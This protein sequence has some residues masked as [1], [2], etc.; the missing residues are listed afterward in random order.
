MDF[1]FDLSCYCVLLFFL[2]K[3]WSFVFRNYIKCVVD[4]LE[5]LVVI[6]DF[7]L[8]Y[9]VFGIFMV[10]VLMVFYQLEILVEEIILSWFS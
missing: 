5:V 6:E 1:L 10:K 8:E 3:V 7:F 2:L 9:E 4:Y